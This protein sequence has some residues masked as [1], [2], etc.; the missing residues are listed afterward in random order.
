MLND[1]C[2]VAAPA[3]LAV[4]DDAMSAS[5]SIGVASVLTLAAFRSCTAY[6]HNAMLN[7]W[8]TLTSEEFQ[9]KY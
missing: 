6:K 3:A 8:E 9:K 2:P 5:P 7:A 1:G 4:L